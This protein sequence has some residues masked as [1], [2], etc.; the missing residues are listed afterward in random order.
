MLVLGKDRVYFDFVILSVHDDP[1][2]DVWKRGLL[3]AFDTLVQES[4]SQCRSDYDDLGKFQNSAMVIDEVVHDAVFV[5]GV[6]LYDTSGRLLDG[7][8][9]VLLAPL[10]YV[11]RHGNARVLGHHN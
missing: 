6:N 8:R 3:N 4:T 11:A 10:S 2:F 5:E 9:R 7:R 1:V